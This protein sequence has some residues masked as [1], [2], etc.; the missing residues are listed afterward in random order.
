MTLPDCRVL[1]PQCT[2]VAASL[3]RVIAF[4]RSLQPLCAHPELCP[5]PVC[6]LLGRALTLLDQTLA[7]RPLE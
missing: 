2:D 7:A 1:F 5:P 4:V 6:D 3:Q